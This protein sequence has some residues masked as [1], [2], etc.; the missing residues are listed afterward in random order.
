[1]RSIVRL[2]WWALL[3]GIFMLAL[4]W[5]FLALPVFVDIR[6]VTLEE[7]LSDQIGQ[8]LYIKEDAR[9]VLGPTSH[10]HA[11]MVEI[12][13]AAIPDVTLA[14]LKILEFDLNL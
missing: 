8:R 9:I 6:R 13:S 14:E 7:F 3:F 10:V 4:G 11:G 2:I 1:M 5:A 12:P